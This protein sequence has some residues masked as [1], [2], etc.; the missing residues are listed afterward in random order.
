MNVIETERLVLR[1]QTVEDAGFIFTLMNDPAW[2]RYIGDRGVRTYEAAHSYIE[3]S[4]LK[5]YDRHGF[6]LY[7]MEQ[8]EEGTPVGIRGLIKRDSLDDVDLGFALAS[9]HRGK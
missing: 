6:G 5:M 4:T 8:K 9:E 1:Y 7:L 3:E 2:L